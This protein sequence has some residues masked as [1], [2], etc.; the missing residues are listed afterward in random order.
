MV[1]VR[2][3]LAELLSLLSKWLCLVLA[4]RQRVEVVTRAGSVRQ[5]RSRHRDGLA[6]AVAGGITRTAGLVQPVAATAESLAESLMLWKDDA[7]GM[8][9][10]TRMPL[11][12]RNARSQLHR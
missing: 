7:H 3:L 9:P 8:V 6:V 1:V 5:M 11:L 12:L 2:R 10:L 4:N